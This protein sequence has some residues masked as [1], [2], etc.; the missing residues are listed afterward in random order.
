MMTEI[1]ADFA[2]QESEMKEELKMMKESL[3]KKKV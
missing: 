3:L 2:R 1:S